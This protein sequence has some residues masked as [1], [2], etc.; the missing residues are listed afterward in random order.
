MF[1][2][3]PDD[4]VNFPEVIIT[5]YRIDYQ[6]IPKLRTL[7]LRYNAKAALTGIFFFVFLLF[8]YSFH[9][10][11]RTMLEDVLIPG[12]NAVTVAAMDQLCADLRQ[13]KDFLPSF[14]HFCRCILGGKPL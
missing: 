14:Q 1:S 5:G 12:D 9:P 2:Y 4:C 6:P 8:A 3:I 13:Q 10:D 11:I 7:P